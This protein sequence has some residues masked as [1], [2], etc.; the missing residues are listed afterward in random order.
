MKRLTIL[1]ISLLML[2]VAAQAYAYSVTI[3]KTPGTT[4]STTALTGSSTWGDDMDGMSVTAFFYNAGSETI[5]WADTGSG[6]GAAAGTGWSLAESGDTF[7]SIWT[8]SV[9]P[10]PGTS[11]TGLLIDAGAGDAV[12]D[13]TFGG[14]AGTTGSA[15][16]RD[17]TVTSTDG[18]GEI[19]AT[20]VDEVA[21]TG[22]PAVGDL[23][24]YLDIQF[25]T[26]DFGRGFAGTLEFQQDTDSLNLAG[27]IDPVPE[28]T[29]M[30]LLGSGL[31][32]LAGFRR[33]F[34]K[35]S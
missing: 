17:F 30:L 16:G 28:P 22:N 11:I 1:F 6:A 20:Y 10:T 9:T 14:S 27:D 8:L 12:F 33:R 3:V 2:F 21:L 24:R 34:L 26:A 15:S 18:S 29:T 7:T 13:T 31:F 25:S 5:A 32:G 19:V 4:Q 35:Q 23:F